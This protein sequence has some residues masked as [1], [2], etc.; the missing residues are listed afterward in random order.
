[1]RRLTIVAVALLT[2]LL[3]AAPALAVDEVNTKRL[4][5]AVTVNGILATSACSSG[6]PTRT[7]APA[8]RARPATTPRPPTSRS[9]CEAAGYKVTEQ[10]FAFPFFRELAPAVLEQ[11]SP[12]PTDYETGTFD[13][14]RQRR[15]HR[16]AG[17]DQRHRDPA[18]AGRRARSLGL[19]GGGLRR[20]P[21]PSRRSR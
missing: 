14:L 11:V 4:R 1:M 17:P 3:A 5:N 15:G 16:A 12:T 20:R 7:A 18:D 21:R 13:V 9:A 10:E 19:R 2:A 6:S 8:P